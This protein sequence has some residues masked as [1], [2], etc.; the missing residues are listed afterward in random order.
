MFTS[1]TRR[2]VI[3]FTGCLTVRRMLR[4]SSATP[5][6]YSTTMSRSIAASDSPTSTPTPWPKLGPALPGMR[7]RIMPNA[8]LPLVPMA[9]TPATSRHALPAIFCTTPSATEMFPSFVV[10]RSPRSRVA[11]LVW[12]LA[13]AG[14]C[15][16]VLA[17]AVWF[18]EHAP[19][20]AV[21]MAVFQSD[22]TAAGTSQHLAVFFSAVLWDPRPA[23]GRGSAAAWAAFVW[24]VVTARHGKQLELIAGQDAAGAGGWGRL[25]GD[26]CPGRL[27]GRL[28]NSGAAPFRDGL[29]G[30]APAV[31]QP[32]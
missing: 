24:A 5:T 8:R 20:D 23:A 13:V 4:P 11:G 14:V 1:T 2:P 22:T 17:A 12:L 6:P 15:S 10:S 32:P 3:R 21:V 25:S 18:I 29:P 31:R 27:S 9:C 26:P 28:R 16:L 19:S 30:R 7:S